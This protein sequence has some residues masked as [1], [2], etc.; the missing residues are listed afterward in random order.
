MIKYFCLYRVV[1]EKDGGE[2]EMDQDEQDEFQGRGPQTRSATGITFV[3]AFG[4]NMNL[5]NQAQDRKRQNLE[6]PPL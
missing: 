6:K 2:L 5:L 4:L 3:R 1:V